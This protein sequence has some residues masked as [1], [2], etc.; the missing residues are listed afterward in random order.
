[1]LRIKTSFLSIMSRY[2]QGFLDSL[3]WFLAYDRLFCLQFFFCLPSGKKEVY[4][5]VFEGTSAC[6]KLNF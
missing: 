2:Y 3:G 1:M 5:L 6:L 4:V